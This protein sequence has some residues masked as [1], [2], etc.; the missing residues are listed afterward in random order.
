MDA[1]LREMPSPNP[2]K[3]SNFCYHAIR[4]LNRLFQIPAPILFKRRWN[5]LQAKFSREKRASTTGVLQK[6]GKITSRSVFTL[7]R[8]PAIGGFRDQRL[9]E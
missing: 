3:D 5:T 6:V 1:R 8:T 9:Q 2:S 4:C 7:Q